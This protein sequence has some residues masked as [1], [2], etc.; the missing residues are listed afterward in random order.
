MQLTSN[1]AYRQPFL[2][3]QIRTQ[4]GLNSRSPP[5]GRVRAGPRDRRVKKWPLLQSPFAAASERR[6]QSQPV[7]SYTREEWFAWII[8][9]LASLSEMKRVPNHKVWKSGGWEDKREQ[10]PVNNSSWETATTC[11]RTDAS[12]VAALRWKTA[13]PCTPRVT[14]REFIIMNFK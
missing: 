4:S 1:Q 3:S 7:G 5:A 9:A 10:G 8:D 13:H 2:W 12:V 11:E 14:G 6:Y